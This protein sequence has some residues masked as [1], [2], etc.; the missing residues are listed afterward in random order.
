MSSNA[1]DVS[2]KWLPRVLVVEDEPRMREMLLRSVSEMGIPA[3]GAR[4]AEDAA[5]LIAREPITILLLDLNLPGEQGLEFLAQARRQYPHLQAIIITGFGSLEA[6]KAAIH[7]DVIEF[8]TKP[9]ALDDLDAALSRAQQR[10][11]TLVTQGDGSPAFSLAFDDAA[12]NDD[13][14]EPPATLE[15]MERQHILD[16]LGR[17]NGNRATAARELGI[18]ERTLYY[19]LGR[20]YPQRKRVTET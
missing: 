16:A 1:V 9:F 18:S 3:T 15:E 7:L 10:L 12:D 11:Q 4:C 2:R 20:Y 5:Q 6:A 19:R 8:L 14:P 17:N 13:A